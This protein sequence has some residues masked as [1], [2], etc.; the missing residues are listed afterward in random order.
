M[1]KA[2]RLTSQF[3]MVLICPESFYENELFEGIFDKVIFFTK[4]TKLKQSKY[5]QFL[6]QKLNVSEGLDNMIKLVKEEVPDLIHTFCE[7]YVHIEKLLK[8]TTFPVV[9]AD[10][11][12][13]S[14]ISFGLDK[15]D[16]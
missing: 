8:E 4:K 7:P 13:F 14:G 6:A 3:E 2:V 11:H 12:D 9:M 16:K 10:G 5:Y 15:I 1:A